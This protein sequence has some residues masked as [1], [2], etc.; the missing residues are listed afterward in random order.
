[1]DDILGGEGFKVEFVRGVVVGGNGLGVGVDHDGF[2]TI[3]AQGEAGVDAAVIEFNALTNAIGAPAEDEDLRFLGGAGFI[4]I[5]IVGG[6]VVGGVCL[7]LGR[8]SVDEPVGGEEFLFL[9]PSADGTGPG[10]ELRFR[11]GQE[12]GEVEVGKTGEPGFAEKRKSGRVAEPGLLFKLAG[13]FRDFADVIEKPG[14]NGGDL[15]NLLEGPTLIQGV[16]QIPEP[17]GVGGAE[18]I[19]ELILGNWRGA[20]AEIKPT[21]LAL[22]VEGA[23]GLHEGFA[24]GAADAH[25]LADAFHGGGQDGF[26]S[27]EFLESKTGNFGD[28]IIEGGFEGGRGFPGDIVL[29]LVE[30][31]SN[32]ELRGDF[33]DGKPGGFGGEGGGAG[34]TGV[35]FDNDH[36]A[37]LGTDRELD[38]GTAGLDADFPDH[39]EG[40][41]PHAL[42]FAIGE[43][44]GGGDGDAVPGVDAH[45]V[46]VFDGA[47]D[48]AVVSAIAHHLHLVL[49][50]TKKGLLDENFRGGGGVK[51]LGGDGLELLPIVGDTATGPPEGEGR[52]NDKR[53]GAD[54]GHGRAGLFHGVGGG[55]AGAFKANLFHAVLEELAILAFADGLHLG[56]DQFDVVSTEGTGLVEGHGGVEGGLAAKGGEQGVRLFLGED[57]FHHFRGDRLDVG[58]VGELRIGHNRGRVAVHEN[59]PVALFAEGFAGLDAGVVELAGLTDDNWA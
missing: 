16:T 24:K 17:G 12:T 32:G 36:P 55:R 26:G 23:K 11:A 33:G 8:A 27:R 21:L 14:I 6:V 28:H 51:A 48:H 45:G 1:M 2:K 37:G 30:G 41:V 35:H 4:V 15:M 38:V 49:L 52:A 31:V 59:D 29:E 58:A 22:E 50:P 39:R 34:D 47:D 56:T 57:V 19:G 25:G 20:G 54:L 5:R 10:Q 53:K 9:P 44:L 42:I 13:D 7:K 46:K 40:G 18:K 43:G 3:L